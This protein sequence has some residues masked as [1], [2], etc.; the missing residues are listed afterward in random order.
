MTGFAS[1]PEMTALAFHRTKFPADM[2][3]DPCVLSD[4]AFVFSAGAARLVRLSR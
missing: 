1:N 3:R 4:P 2:A